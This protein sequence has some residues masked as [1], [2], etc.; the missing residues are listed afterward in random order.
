MKKSLF[1]LILCGLGLAQVSS[2]VA[3]CVVGGTDFDVTGK[4][5][6]AP[7]L[8][9]NGKPDGGGWYDE[10]LDWDKLCKGDMFIGPNAVDH[11]GLL[12]NTAAT[13]GSLDLSDS[14]DIEKIFLSTNAT[15]D[16][17]GVQYGK[18]SHSA[19]KAY[20]SIFESQ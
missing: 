17:S 3:Q 18:S 15:Q 5:L 4:D 19:A 20:Q 2:S 11:K 12:S 9:S 7:I 8:K 1:S 13:S 16:E 14:K 10:N 6:C